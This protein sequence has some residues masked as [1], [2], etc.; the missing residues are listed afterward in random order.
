MFHIIPV[1]DLRDGGVV[2]A[3]R[4]ARGGYPPLRSALCVGNAPTAVVRGLLGLFP[5]PVIY[6]A[7]LDA[8]EG[9]GDNGAA[10]DALAAAFPE[11]CF[12]IDAGFRTPEDVGLDHPGDPVLGSESLAGV[13]TL[14]ALQA[15]PLWPR[16]VLSL[17]FRDG[18]VG[19]PALLARTDL[20]PQRVIA[21]T[22]AR[23]GS[24]E[25]PDMARLAG[26]RRSAGHTRLFAAGGVRHAGDAQALAAQ[27][28][29]GAL[30]ATAL[31]DGRIG[32]V[33]LRALTLPHEDGGALG[34]ITRRRGV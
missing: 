5:F 9:T 33:E 3:R 26:L 32:A 13:E 18:F 24:G 2:H 23:V 6:A 14:E 12:W 10:L 31:H 27:G 25:G 16:L 21:M 4:G 8:I 19:P 11:I 17:D 15:T 29:A 34:P 22:L 30:V 20:W 28:I 7:D 1:L